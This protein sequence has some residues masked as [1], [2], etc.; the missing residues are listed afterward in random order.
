M[1][2]AYIAL[3]RKAPGS[4]SN[5]Q[6]PLYA[7]S[8]YAAMQFIAGFGGEDCRSGLICSSVIVSWRSVCHEAPTLQS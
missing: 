6:L 1:A 8:S 4:G 3:H 7:T 2:I 5:F